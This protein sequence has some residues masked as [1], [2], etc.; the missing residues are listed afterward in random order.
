MKTKPNR[1]SFLRRILSI[2]I[3]LLKI[4]LLILEIFKQLL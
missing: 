4:I 2:A 3:G 1:Y